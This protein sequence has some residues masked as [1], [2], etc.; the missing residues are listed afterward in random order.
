LHYFALLWKRV[1][2]NCSCFGA[3]CCNMLQYAAMIGSS[4]AWWGGHSN[5]PGVA[6]GSETLGLISTGCRM[7]H[8]VHKHEETGGKAWKPGQQL[9]GA[10]VVLN[11]HFALGPRRRMRGN[12]SCMFL[13]LCR[14]L[15]YATI[16]CNE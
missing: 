16:C 4:M 3:E 9:G 2:E 10:E 5:N 6:W 15:Q 1:R 14:I 13:L 11:W 12:C 8:V 7:L